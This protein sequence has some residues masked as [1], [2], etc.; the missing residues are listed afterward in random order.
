MLGLSS[1]ISDKLLFFS[2]SQKILR[3]G[4]SGKGGMNHAGE[5]IVVI[6]A[7]LGRQFRDKMS[8]QVKV[9]ASLTQEIGR[10]FLAS[11]F[12]AL[13]TESR[14]TNDNDI[15]EACLGFTFVPINFFGISSLALIAT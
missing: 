8:T 9:N 4:C 13:I 3:N 6:S 15:I 11:S 7:H 10:T 2:D 5:Q 12:V 14:L 1:T